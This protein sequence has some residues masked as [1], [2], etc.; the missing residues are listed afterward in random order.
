MKPRPFVRDD[1]LEALESESFDVLVVGGGITGVGAALDAASRGLRTAL[2]ERDDF[3]SGTSSRSSKLVHGGIR[4]LQQG[5]I[6]LVYQALAE[7]QRLLENAPHLVQVLPFLIPI[8]STEGLIPKKLARAMGS[9]MWMYD[10]TGGARIRRLHK[11]IDNRAVLAHMPTLPLDRLAGGYL[12]Y[13]ASADDARLTLAVARTAALHFGAVM[14]NDTAVVAVGKDPKGCID[15][16]EV[17]AS[18]HR[19]LIR[20]RAVVNATGVWADTIRSLDEGRDPESI[21]PAKGIH[22]TV[23]WHK[24]RNDIAAV[25]PVRSDQRSIFVVPWGDFTYIGTTDTDYDGP[26]DDPQCEPDDIR[27]L[28]DA[29]NAVSSEGI[30]ESDIVGTWAGLRPLVRSAHTERTADMSR[31]HKVRVSSSGLV[32]V[33]GGKLTTYREMA[34]D[35]VDAAVDEVLLRDVPRGALRSHTRRLPIRGAEGYETLGVASV[36]YPGIPSRVIAHLGSRFGGEA[37]VVMG[38]IEDNPDLIAPLVEGLPYVRAEALFSARHE[39]M[40]T[41]DDLLSRRTRARLLGR[42]PSARSAPAVAD[43][44]A[45]EL[46]WDSERKKREVKDYVSR[47]EEERRSA[48]LPESDLATS[49]GA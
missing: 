28:L 9:A 25:V 8:F 5:D 10:L 36:S 3:A 43:L 2:V 47:T 48:C 45:D 49:I 21:R 17:E 32:S 42:D 30:S 31:R 33:T 23:P 15:A 39:M 46:G 6:G 12:Y 44:V 11:R 27:Y 13:D 37:R 20:A 18:G 14:A 35:A 4:Y 7:R 41:L 16:V 24:V 22:I 40:Q 26:L 34:A 38:M 29:F 1:S 19:I